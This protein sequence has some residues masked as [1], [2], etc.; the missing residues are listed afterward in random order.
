MRAFDLMT[1]LLGLGLVA[2]CSERALP[3]PDAVRDPGMSP[4]LSSPLDLAFHPDL[5]I[6]PDLATVVDLAFRPDLTTPVDLATRDL[7]LVPDLASSDLAPVCGN[8]RRDGLEGCD[9]GNNVSGDGCRADC[10][11]EGAKL[12][13]FKDLTGTGVGV[14]N[15]TATRS[16]VVYFGEA[17][18]PTA[19]VHRMAQNGTV[20]QDIIPNLPFE[21]LDL[22]AVTEDLVIGG[23]ST[24]GAST[25]VGWTAQTGALTT[26]Y[27]ELRTH[28]L[29]SVA[30][31]DFGLTKTLYADNNGFLRRVVS[32]TTSVAYG[33]G[34]GF[35]LIASRPNGTTASLANNVVYA[36]D[37][38]GNFASLWQYTPSGSELILHMTADG[39]ST[40]YLSCIKFSSYVGSGG[41]DSGALWAVNAAGTEARP[42][43]DNFAQLDSL[44]WDPS[45]NQ[46]VIVVG[47]N[48]I[49]PKIVRVPLKR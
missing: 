12:P 37:G 34:P 35:T 31:A 23:G 2:G 46:L 27:S 14:Y 3:I 1:A 47:T 38:A 48:V 36:D 19:R 43:I 30:A 6:P 7:A 13:I 40:V 41:C 15:I 17:R 28:T 45:T 32:A 24:G 5:A 22:V 10:V 9:D 4:D 29:Y 8:G 25:I 21:Y 39:E 16:G 11:I 49:G 20:T 42:F 26:L 44:T 33:N 18:I